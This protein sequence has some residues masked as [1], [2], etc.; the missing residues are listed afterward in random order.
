MIH[1]LLSSYALLSTYN[2]PDPLFLISGREIHTRPF[3]VVLLVR[4]L[5]CKV[6]SIVIFETFVSNSALRFYYVQYRAAWYVCTNVSEEHADSMFR[7]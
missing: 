2:S 5:L 4:N 7:A 1:Y 6:S 3:T